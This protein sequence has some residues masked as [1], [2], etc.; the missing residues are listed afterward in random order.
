MGRQG[1]PKKIAVQLIG[2]VDTVETDGQLGESPV[3]TGSFTSR[4]S[5][6]TCSLFLSLSPVELQ[7]RRL[8][9]SSLS[10]VDE[11]LRDEKGLLIVMLRL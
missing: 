3:D 1:K 7:C 11:R 9:S 2:S 10:V 6:M 5:S 8:S 4:C